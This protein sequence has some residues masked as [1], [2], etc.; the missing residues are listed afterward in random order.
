V[1][2]AN[3]PF[4]FVA[5][6]YLT[7]V[8]RECA[9]NLQDLAK[10]IAAV[11]EASIFCHTFQSLE[12]HNYVSYSSDF[13]QWVVASCNEEQ[14]AE[15]LGTV[16]VKEFV[17]IQDLR[18]VLLNIVEEHL[19][20]YPRSADRPA[21]EPFYFC[22]TTE[23]TLPLHF[24][25]ANLAELADGIRHLSLHSLH[26]HFINSRLRLHLRTNDFS[27]WIE[28]EMDLPKLSARINRI[29]FYTNTLEGVRQSILDC[30]QPSSNRQ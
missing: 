22:E 7:R 26:Y 14:L 6:S 5:A 11:P 28:K 19:R 8:G 24:R 10:N 21:L 12:T 23:V 4:Q 25:A 27:N 2:Q 18:A 17:T 20:A 1:K 15:R 30:I 16:D 13:A 29:D 3:E 9:N